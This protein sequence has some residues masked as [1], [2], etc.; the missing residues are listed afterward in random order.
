[1]TQ[2]FVR[3]EIIVVD[4]ASEDDTVSVLHQRY[5]GRIIVVGLKANRRVAAATN[6]GFGNSAGE[7]IALLGDDDYWSDSK[8]LMKQLSAFDENGSGLGIVGT[9]WSERH[10]SGELSARRPGEP[11]NWT[12]RLLQSGGIICGSTPLIRRSA[13]LAAGG[14]DERMPRGTDSDLFRRIV[15]AGYQ[16]RIIQQDTTVVDVSHGLTR[17]TASRGFREAGRIAWVH[18]YILWKYRRYYPRYPK[19]M[20][21]RIKSLALGFVAAIY[22]TLTHFIQ[23]VTVERKS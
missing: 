15:L 3:T 1:M 11:S 16:A 4:D 23:G 7:F 22:K 8:K 14:L 18:G 2:Q 9:W 20:W 6:I 17:M 10:D 21:K 19:A 13:W 5:S 12:E